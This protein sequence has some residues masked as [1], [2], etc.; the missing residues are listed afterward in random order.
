MGQVDDFCSH[1]KVNYSLYCICIPGERPRMLLTIL[2]P[3]EPMSSQQL[4]FA[5][6]GF[7]SGRSFPDLPRLRGLSLTADDWD[8]KST[9]CQST[10]DLYRQLLLR[11]VARHNFVWTKNRSC[12]A[13]THFDSPGRIWSLTHVTS[14]VQY[15]GTTTAP[16][17]AESDS[18]TW[19]SQESTPTCIESKLALGGLSTLSYVALNVIPVV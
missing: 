8:V 9:Y 17:R 1:W 3:T 18:V 11:P 13:G 12:F 5:L 16:R 4:T 7:L 19:Q 14:C 6:S 10:R 2:T 15:L